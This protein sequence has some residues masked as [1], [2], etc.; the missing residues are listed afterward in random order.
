MHPCILIASKDGLEDEDLKEREEDPM[1]AWPTAVSL[2][3]MRREEPGLGLAELCGLE[4]RWPL[5]TRPPTV[6]GN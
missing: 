1:L 2:Q 6:P 5:L 4:N 3:L